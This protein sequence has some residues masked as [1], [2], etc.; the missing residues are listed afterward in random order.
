MAD[1]FQIQTGTCGTRLGLHWHRHSV[2]QPMDCSGRVT[3][4]HYYRKMASAGLHGHLCHSCQRLSDRLQED[5]IYSI[6]HDCP[7]R[8]IALLQG[9][10]RGP[11]HYDHS[12]PL[13]RQCRARSGPA[14]QRPPDGHS[15][16]RICWPLRA[17]YGSRLAHRE[18]LRQD[19]VP[20]SFAQHA[21]ADHGN[22]EALTEAD[23]A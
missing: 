3:P 4:D 1:H 13:D 15:F 10:P 6:H 19:Y 5:R 2:H 23:D 7:C 21:P 12:P 11:A 9:C 16:R 20:A 18:F 8:S 14:D 17:E 22:L